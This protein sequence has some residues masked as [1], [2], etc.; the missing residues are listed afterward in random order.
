MGKWHRWGGMMT[1]AVGNIWL[2]RRW[3]GAAGEGGGGR[4]RQR[5]GEGWCDDNVI[6]VQSR[7]FR[8]YV[9]A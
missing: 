2:Q 5:R 3:L 6:M 1:D 4:Q 9:A 8:S 7:V